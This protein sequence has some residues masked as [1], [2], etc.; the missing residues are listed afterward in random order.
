MMKVY[1]TIIKYDEDF[2]EGSH[3]TTLDNIYADL[4]KARDRIKELA[5][6]DIS[7]FCEDE[8]YSVKSPD[9]NTIIVYE[10]DDIYSTYCIK[11]KELL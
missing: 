10:M 4:E 1:V 5:D 11:E 2:Y 8:D 7:R 9:A 6:E 3:H